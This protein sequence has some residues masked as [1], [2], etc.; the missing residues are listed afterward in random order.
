MR[1]LIYIFPVAIFDAIQDADAVWQLILRLRN[2][3]ALTRLRSNS[4]SWADSVTSQQYLTLFRIGSI[5]VKPSRKTIVTEAPLR[6][7]LP[8]T[9]F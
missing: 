2:I 3:S 9:H 8:I 7:A 4:L 6:V 5:L 1:Q